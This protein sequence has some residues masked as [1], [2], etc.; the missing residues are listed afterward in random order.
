MFPHRDPHPPHPDE[1]RS[2]HP[3]KSD[4]GSADRRQTSDQRRFFRPGQVFRPDVA[5]RMKKPN[6]AI[7][8][9]IRSRRAIG[10]VPIAGG[11]GQAEVFENGLA[12]QSAR[13]DMLNLESNHRECLRRMTVGT[14][15]RKLG[16]NFQL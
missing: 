13:P 12:T 9:C 2:I 6:L 11:A 7:R 8:Q 3:Q 16:A 14:A 10:F 1:L 15:T 5:L 4:G